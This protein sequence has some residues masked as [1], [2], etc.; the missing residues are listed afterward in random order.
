MKRIGFVI[1]RLLAV[2]LMIC[3]APVFLVLGFVF[4]VFV[5]LET[6]ADAVDKLLR[7][8]TCFALAGLLTASGAIL[9]CVS[10]STQS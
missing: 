1:L 3:G 8:Y 4:G 5:T 10:R 2:T 6:P 9:W 7:I